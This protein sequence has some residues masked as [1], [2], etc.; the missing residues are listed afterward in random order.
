LTAANA[1]VAFRLR[2]LDARVPEP[3]LLTASL[4]SAP[5]MGVG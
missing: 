3:T 5:C 1:R 2:S 4:D